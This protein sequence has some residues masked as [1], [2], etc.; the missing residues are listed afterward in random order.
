MHKKTGRITCFINLSKYIKNYKIKL[1]VS[2]A[3]HGLYKVMP[4]LI[5]FVTALII[6]KAII[7]ELENIGNYFVVIAILIVLNAILNYLDILV[8]H[9]MAYRILTDLRGKAIKRVS[10]IAPGGMQ[11]EE[12]GD[13]ISVVLEDMEI[14][15]WFYAHTTNQVI[16]AILLPLVSLLVLGAF[17]IW[18]PLVLILFIVC[19]LIIPVMAKKKSNEQGQKVQ[20][21]LGKLN[22]NIVDGIQGLRDIITFQW[23]NKY[24]EK[25]F[26]T[27]DEY[28]ESVKKY[29]TRATKET[30]L[31]NLIIGISS[32]IL[33]VMIVALCLK[34]EFGVKWILPLISLSSMIYAPLQETLAMSSNY[35]RILGAAERVLRLLQKES[36]VVDE[37]KVDSLSDLETEQVRVNYKNVF[38]SYPTDGEERRLEI[39]KDICF[40]VTKNET[41]VL[42]GKS[43]CGKSTCVKLLQR[44]WDVDGGS[45]DINGVDIK[46]LK[47][48]LLRSLISVVPQDTYIFNMS[49]RDNL[50]LAKLSAT[51]EEIIEALKNASAYD[52][53]KG[54][55]HGIDTEVG[56]KGLSLSGGEKQ[57]VAIAQAF[58]KDSPI[59]I[60]DEASA[61][62]DSENEKIVNEAI[63]KLKEGRVTLMIAH[64]LSTIQGA[65]KIIVIEDGKINTVG[66]YHK[67]IKESEFFKTLIGK[68]YE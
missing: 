49:V 42:V 60:L 68:E 15:E 66:H 13:I 46:G 1:I 38:F 28:N 35:G 26:R 12:S 5:G 32:L 17:S 19:M 34:G 45:I 61:N 64:R 24:V 2:I 67:I 62:L 7:N 58:L 11:T 43:G 27:N 50:R 41:A 59:L 30:S 16:V 52:F 18:L 51:E 57:R 20:S 8:S 23:Q 53:V 21:R 33:T 36:P 31:T 48:D 54:L 14:L 37:G 29:T 10:E 40:E 63:N 44:F 55:P 9:D 6:G 39:C 56:E 22:A 4:I 47:I 65:D 3:I 25:L